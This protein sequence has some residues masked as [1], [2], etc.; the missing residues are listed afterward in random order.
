MLAILV[1]AL[2]HHVPKQ[3]AALPGVDQ[4]FDGGTEHIE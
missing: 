3:D 4:I 2:T 1:A